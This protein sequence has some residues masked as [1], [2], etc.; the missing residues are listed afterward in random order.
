[1]HAGRTVRNSL[2]RPNL[3]EV[4][5]EMYVLRWLQAPR[6][7]AVTRERVLP[8]R[9]QPND[10]RQPIHC[11]CAEQQQSRSAQEQSSCPS[12]M[13]VSSVTAHSSAEHRA[14]MQHM[15][16]GNRALTCAEGLEDLRCVLQ[17]TH[18]VESARL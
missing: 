9:M 6:I 3:S 18:V 7:R 11:W 5:K 15:Y 13:L 16:K 12:T 10:Q 17:H 1:M 8:V 14:R 4:R 2:R